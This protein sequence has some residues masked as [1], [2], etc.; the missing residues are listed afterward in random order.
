MRKD[1]TN[2][3]IVKLIL[4]LELIIYISFIYLDFTAKYKSVYSTSLKYI[5]IL[6]C[7]TLSFLIGN[8]G[9]DKEDTKLLQTA[10]CFTVAADL[11]LVIL[12]YYT[13]GIFLF[14]FVQITYIIRHRRGVD[15]KNKFYKIIGFIVL[16]AFGSKMVIGNLKILNLGMN[17]IKENT[18]AIGA[19]YAVLL[20]YS[21]YTA[22]KTFQGKVYTLYSCFFICIGMT[23][24]FLCDINVGISG[25]VNNV[26]LFGIDVESVSRFLVWI[27]Y[28]PSQILLAL[29]GYKA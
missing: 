23:L 14:C 26:F 15:K 21:L 16:F 10:F 13:M 18:I 4:C 8:R 24:F 19:I 12:S 5:G 17:H 28:L 20:C 9:Y 6:L 1:I 11:C 7:L 29:S 27:F 22:F 3:F 2:L 25:I